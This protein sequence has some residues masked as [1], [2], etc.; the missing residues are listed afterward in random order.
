M[1]IRFSGALPNLGEKL[2]I[3]SAQPLPLA[4]IIVSSASIFNVDIGLACTVG[5]KS[6][7]WKLTA[8]VN[9]ENNN[10]IL[11]VNLEDL[12]DDQKVLIE[13]ATEEFKENLLSYS[14]T[15]ESVIQKTSLPRVLLHG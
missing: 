12:P 7:D 5:P 13:Q 9:M 2:E 14:R 15:R 8:V 4:L 10:T 11:K 6:F 3:R 1:I